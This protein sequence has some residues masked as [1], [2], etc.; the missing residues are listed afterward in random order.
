MLK[1]VKNWFYLQ[2]NCNKNITLLFKILK[3]SSTNVEL[4]KENYGLNRFSIVPFS[5][6]HKHSLN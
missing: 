4:Y 2:S 3:I 5:L 6:I 1:E